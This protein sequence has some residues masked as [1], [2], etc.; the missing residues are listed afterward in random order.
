MRAELEVVIPGRL[1]CRVG[2][3]LQA[4]PAP[5]QLPGVQLKH[6]GGQEL[7]WEW[8]TRKARQG[9]R[10]GVPACLCTVDR[11]SRTEGQDPYICDPLVAA[12]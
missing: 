6:C 5:E 8:E 4:A 1:V 3:V 2:S 9:R 11:Q 12:G 10:C 7:G